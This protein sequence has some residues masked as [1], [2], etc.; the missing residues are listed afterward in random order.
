MCFRRQSITPLQNS[1]FSVFPS[2][3][4]SLCTTPW[5]SKKNYQHGL[6]VALFE[7][8]FLQPKYVSPTHLELLSLCF[9]VTGKTPGLISRINFVKK[10]FVFIGHCD[11]VL[12]R[13][14]SIFPL[15]RCQTVWNKMYTQLSLSQIVFQNPKNYSLGGVQRF[16]YHSWCDLTVVFDQISNSINV[17]LSLSRFWTAIAAIIIFYQLPSVL[18]LGIPPNNVWLV[19][20]LIPISLLHQC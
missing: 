11:N 13:C 15:L 6:D 7:L 2:G 4:N 3:M 16:C 9:A 10:I 12:A 17:Y 14:D 20:S 5:E 8:Q 18:K 19:Q 1:V